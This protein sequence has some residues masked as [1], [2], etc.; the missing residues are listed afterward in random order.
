MSFTQFIELLKV[1]K[2]PLVTLIIAFIVLWR[3]QK[4]FV[5]F[6]SRLRSIGTDGLRTDSS[7]EQILGQQTGVRTQ[8]EVQQLMQSFD[9][10]ALLD[11]E[12]TLRAELSRRSLQAEAAIQVLVRH[13]AQARLYLAHEVAYRSIFGSQIRFLR[14]LNSSPNGMTLDQ[15]EEFYKNVA[16][17]FPTILRDRS[18]A[19]YFGYLSSHNLISVQNNHSYITDRGRDFLTWMVRIGISDSRP[20]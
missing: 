16:E 12:N 11:E 10:P 7:G 19:D 4:Q 9:S 2:W 15:A 13:Y 20:L 18:S 6:F 3:F 14:E 1:L 8:D 5:A 17:T